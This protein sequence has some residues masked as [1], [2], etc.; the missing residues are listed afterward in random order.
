MHIS[1][2]FFHPPPSYPRNSSSF[3]LSFHPLLSSPSLP[4]HL[5]SPLTPYSPLPL[6]LLISLLLSLLTLLSLSISP[7]LFSSHSLLSSPSLSSSL[8]L[9][10]SFLS[11]F[12]ANSS[13]PMSKTF[14]SKKKLRR[15][16]KACRPSK[17]TQPSFR[18][19][20]SSTGNQRNRSD[21]GK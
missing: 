4:L 1:F 5:S 11:L 16:N 21:R 10:P 6:Y 20:Q 18:R 9:S 14:T 19:V 15:W 12:Q 13:L 7:S 17:G 2:L 3:L 8:T